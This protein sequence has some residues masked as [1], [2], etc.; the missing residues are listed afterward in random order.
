MSHGHKHL[1]VQAA[2][3]EL[4]VLLNWC[5]SATS[6]Q[7]WLIHLGPSLPPLYVCPFSAFSPYIHPSL[8]PSPMS[9]LLTHWPAAFLLSTRTWTRSDPPLFRIY[10][11]PAGKPEMQ[12]A[13]PGRQR[14]GRGPASPYGLTEKN[15]FLQDKSASTS[16]WTKSQGSPGMGPFLK[17]LCSAGIWTP[18]N[19]SD[20]RMRRGHKVTSCVCSNIIF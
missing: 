7:I 6:L 3:K 14:P 1:F 2:E 18:V 8:W 4:E 20:W 9:L 10:A 19:N 13:H 12:A 15:L 17:A 5:S 16:L 11:S